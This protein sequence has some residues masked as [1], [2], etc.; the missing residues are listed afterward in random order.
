MSAVIEVENLVKIYRP[1]TSDE[2]RAVNG[3]SFTVAKGT[4]FGLLGPNG[5]GK[6]TMLRILTTLSR[7]TSGTSRILGIDLHEKP[8]EVRKRLSAVLQDTAVELFLSV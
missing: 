4:I 6:S 8:L 3:M 1:G 7:A 5:A 2:V